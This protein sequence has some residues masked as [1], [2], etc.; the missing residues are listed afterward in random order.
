MLRIAPTT[1]QYRLTFNTSDY[2]WKSS[3]KRSPAELISSPGFQERV[4]RFRDLTFGFTKDKR[5]P[6]AFP[7]SDLFS[8][9]LIYNNGGRDLLSDKLRRDISQSSDIL[10][11]LGDIPSIRAFHW[12]FST[13]LADLPR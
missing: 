13:I 9:I 12:T 10:D 2:G 7:Y 1:L 4:Y 8:A 11:L 5:K 3:I 6:L